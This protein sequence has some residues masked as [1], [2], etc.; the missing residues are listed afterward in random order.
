MRDR[1]QNGVRVGAVHI[2]AICAEIGDRL[3]AALTTG[4]APLP[5]HLLRLMELLL[6]VEGRNATLQ[7]PTEI[8]VR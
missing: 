2:E 4:S 5:P 7:G 3:P 8:D 6:G 1:E